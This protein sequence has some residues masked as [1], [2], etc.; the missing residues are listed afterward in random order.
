[1]S[2]NLLQSRLQAAVQNQ[3]LSGLGPFG[4]IDR[5]KEIIGDLVDTVPEE[6]ALATIETFWKTV[7]VPIP[8]GI[9]GEVIAEALVLKIVERMVRGIYK[10][11][12]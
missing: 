1:M 12:A 10:R 5:L 9:P 11:N 3:Q 2:E 6:Q 7:V 8:W 4:L